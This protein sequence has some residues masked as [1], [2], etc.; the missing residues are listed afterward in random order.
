MKCPN[1]GANYSDSVL[2]LHLGRCNRVEE[3]KPFEEMSLPALREYATK[4]NIDL[5]GATKKG[6]ILA[7]ILE[8]P[9]S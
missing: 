6:D 4:N 3:I 8:A 7:A 1:C 9:K 2:R 5:N